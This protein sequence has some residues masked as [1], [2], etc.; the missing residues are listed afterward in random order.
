ML[1]TQMIYLDIYSSSFHYVFDNI[2]WQ[3]YAAFD[4]HVQEG[5]DSLTFSQLRAVLHALPKPPRLYI[6]QVSKLLLI[7]FLRYVCK[8]CRTSIAAPHPSR[9]RRPS[10]S[11][12]PSPQVP[13]GAKTES[14]VPKGP[15][16]DPLPREQNSTNFPPANSANSVPKVA[17]TRL[18][19]VQPRDKDDAKEVHGTAEVRDA[20]GLKLPTKESSLEW[21]LIQ[22][23]GGGQ[24][25][26]ST[27]ESRAKPLKADEDNLLDP[28]LQPLRQVTIA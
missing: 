4:A 25:A 22:G 21:G 2:L 18:T 3:A 26:T 27:S 24:P 8:S 13:K 11:K 28:V 10:I 9:V 17:P 1:L 12:H 19:T 20:G 23:V 14:S 5:S 6:N 15:G 7:I 16:Y